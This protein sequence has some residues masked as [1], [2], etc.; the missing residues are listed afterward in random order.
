MILVLTFPHYYA[1]L[2]H[3]YTS[4]PHSFPHYPHKIVEISTLLT[5]KLPESLVIHKKRTSIK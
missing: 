5:K 4:F 1:Q 2:K 3:A